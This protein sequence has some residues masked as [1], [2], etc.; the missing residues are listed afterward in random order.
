M[1]KYLQSTVWTNGFF[2]VPLAL[3]IYFGL[4]IHALLI[5]LVFVA[6]TLYHSSDGKKGIYNDYFWAMILISYNLYMCYL[7]RFDFICSLLTFVLVF[8]AFY[9]RY[10]Q[11]N[12]NYNYYHSLWHIASAGITV[13]SILWYA[14]WGI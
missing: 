14:G 7:G 11:G 2:L 5:F 4:Y 13:V 8:V 12:G 6:S 9:F 1:K 3:S 10:Q